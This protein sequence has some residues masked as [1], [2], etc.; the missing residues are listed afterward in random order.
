MRSSKNCILG[1]FYL[2]RLFV[3]IYLRF[4]EI[5]VLSFIPTRT[6]LFAMKV[7][8]PTT[9]SGHGPACNTEQP[10]K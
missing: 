6:I 5:R 2:I 7:L 3:G 9:L 4:A 8:Q 10:Q 1:L